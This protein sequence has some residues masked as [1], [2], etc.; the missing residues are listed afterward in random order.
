MGRVEDGTENSGLS[1]RDRAPNFCIWRSRTVRVKFS[2]R[3]HAHTESRTSRTRIRCAHWDI[4]VMLKDALFT[5]APTFI[6]PPYMPR[7]RLL[8]FTH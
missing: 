3:I 7:R 6:L 5:L 4:I 2:M 1:M 8:Q